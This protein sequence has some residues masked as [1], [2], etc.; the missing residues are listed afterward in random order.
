MH[1]YKQRE[2]MSTPGVSRSDSRLLT[3]WNRKGG[4]RQKK[5][6]KWGS[7]KRVTDN[8]SKSKNLSLFSSHF[9][10][11]K[12]LKSNWDRQK[13]ICN[14]KVTQNPWR[15]KSHFKGKEGDLVQTFFLLCWLKCL[16]TSPVHTE[17][18]HHQRVPSRYWRKS[19]N[20]RRYYCNIMHF[21][22]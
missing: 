3:L 17:V 5:K 22:L 18:I 15:N 16:F 12:G 8:C 14:S 19:K 2:S 6:A 20:G 1:L 13:G 4:E 21:V 7:E 10:I 11:L 9:F